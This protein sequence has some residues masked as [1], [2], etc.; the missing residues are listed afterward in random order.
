MTFSYWLRYIL[1]HNMKFK[2]GHINSASQMQ[3]P[4]ADRHLLQAEL[5][6]LPCHIMQIK[7]ACMLAI[8]NPM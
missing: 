5:S 7:W 1:V 4:C 8:A 2:R 6:V 3:P